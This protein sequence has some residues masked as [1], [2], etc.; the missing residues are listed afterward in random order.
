MSWLKAVPIVGQLLLKAVALY[1]RRQRKKDLEQQEQA[2]DAIKQDPKSRH[3][4]RF[5][6]CAGRVSVNVTSDSNSK[7]EKL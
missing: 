7:R 3:R 5:G 6:D 2:R 1:E 4:E